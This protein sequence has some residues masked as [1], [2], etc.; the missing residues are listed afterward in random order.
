MI[1]YPIVKESSY[2]DVISEVENKES[3]EGEAEVL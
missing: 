1:R 3:Q 2:S